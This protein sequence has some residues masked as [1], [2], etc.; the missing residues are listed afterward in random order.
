MLIFVIV[1]IVKINMTG[2][3]TL[4]KK[5]V[6][7]KITEIDAGKKISTNLRNM[8]IQKG[9]VIEIK[10]ESKLKGPIVID[11]D[12]TEI[13]LGYNLAQKITVESL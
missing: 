9:H 1:K 5:G 2:K 6:K 13:A 4:F 10:R 8:G 12:N 7:V 3:L 11:R